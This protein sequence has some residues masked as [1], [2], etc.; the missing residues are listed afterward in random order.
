MQPERELNTSN[1][2]ID[3]R[4]AWYLMLGHWKLFILSLFLT[5]SC[6]LFYIWYA[7]PVF[8]IT[9]TVLVGDESA[10]I[11]QSILDEVGVIG[12][13][14]NVENEIAIV[15]SRFIMQ[16]TISE[17]NINMR[18][19]AD[20][21]TRYREM[22]LTRP[23]DLNYTLLEDAPAEFEFEID[24]D[25]E[26]LLTA[27]LEWEDNG[28]TTH[29]EYFNINIGEEFKSSIGVFTVVKT[30]GFSEY[31]AGDGAYTK[32]YHFLYE[33]DE[34]VSTRYMEMLSVEPAREK[35]SILEITLEDH[36]RARGEDVLNKLLSVYISNSVE[37]KNMLASN[38]LGFIDNQ[39]GLISDDLGLLEED[40]QKYKVANRISDIGSEAAFFLSQVGELDK[41][42]SEIDVQLSFMD[43]LSSYVASNQGL[44]NAS[45]ASL[46]IQDPLLHELLASIH[47]LNS[48]RES[49]L[50]FTRE[51]NPLVQ[52]LDVRLFEAKQSL[53][54]NIASIRS[55]LL[56][57]REQVSVQQ[58]RLEDKVKGLPKA[59]YELLAMQRKYSIKESLYL[60]LLE[61][62]SEN[63]IMLA[64]TVSDNYVL[65]KAR[66]TDKPISPKKAVI[67]IF[68]LVIGLGL[69]TVW[70]ML[71]S[72]FDTSIKS[73]DD[74]KKLTNIPILGMV[75]HKVS[76][77]QLV[78]SASSSSAVAESF[79][80]LRTN[81]SFITA[82]HDKSA[83]TGSVIQ[84]TS[85]FGSEGKSFCSINLAAS[86]ALGGSNTVLVG[87]DLR[88]P[89]L[90]EYFDISNSQGASTILAKM[91]SFEECIIKTE[92][93]GLDMI[94]A[95]PIPPNPSELLL[96]DELKTLVNNLK[97]T[98][99]Y[100]ILDTPPVGLVSDS[101]VIS[102][103]VDASIYVI[104]QGVTRSSDLDYINEIH[105]S[106][107]VSSISILFNDVKFGRFG[108]GYGYGY[109]E[110][111]KEKKG[112]GRWPNLFG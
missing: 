89:K 69:P 29:S 106:N 104:R 90:A 48:E 62:K 76:D 103:L 26:T 24:I 42:M 4:D 66:G 109:Y 10:D 101:L 64:S 31:A 44:K 108:Y 2:E 75:P 34:L 7:H 11:S 20:L 15:S 102:E 92:V 74:I 16:K 83:G 79:R 23:I 55:G 99:Q 14:K 82:S 111:P 54:N 38:A 87:L 12:K 35:A 43:Y 17:L 13:K 28:G 94:V 58:R 71:M 8:K 30:E 112:K 77:D 107:R 51:D 97:K 27:E 21:G 18:C 86:L 57:S 32:N 41:T 84:L 65:D 52:S 25:D 88:K 96:G 61:K 60:L 5:F 78:V 81:I 33:D 73:K 110:S 53:Q 63:A 22:Y 105:T 70:V 3:L 95:G 46:G 19:V 36:L 45:P 93:N 72:V 9:A 39:L 100:V 6:A 67:L 56:V 47:Q 37:K 85:S 98:Y 59:E 68:A 1:D 91:N 50:K 40:I 80:S 49:L